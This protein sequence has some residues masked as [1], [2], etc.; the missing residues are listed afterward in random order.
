DLMAVQSVEPQHA[1]QF[2]ALLI[3]GD[4]QLAAP[5]EEHPSGEAW[6]RRQQ[7]F[8]ACRVEGADD[9]V[10]KCRFIKSS[11]TAGAVIAGL[12]F[13]LDQQNPSG[14]AARSGESI[15]RGRSRH[16]GTDDDNLVSHAARMCWWLTM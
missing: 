11:G 1:L 8:G 12:G 4:A 10:A 13:P 9:R 3:I 15:A 2:G 7:E 5:G 14:A 16:P 6:R